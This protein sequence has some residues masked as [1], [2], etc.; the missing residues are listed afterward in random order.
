M[1][2]LPMPRRLAAAVLLLCLL[3]GAH[4]AVQ[5]PSQFLG[6]TVGADKQLADYMQIVGYLRALAAASPR[7]HIEE[8]GQTTLGRPFIMAV[9]SSEQNLKNKA[10]YQEIARKLADPRGLAPEQ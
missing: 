10:R 6:F 7:V 5:T 4:A 9:I 3:A 2:V 8:L 1:E